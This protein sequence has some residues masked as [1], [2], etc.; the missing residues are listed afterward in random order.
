M[1]C[2]TCF[3]AFLHCALTSPRRL[4]VS[5]STRCTIGTRDPV[6]GQTSTYRCGL[7]SLNDW[8][9]WNVQPISLLRFFPLVCQEYIL[10]Y[11][12]TIISGNL[13]WNWPNFLS[14]ESL[15]Q[16]I[17]RWRTTYLKKVLLCF[18]GISFPLVSCRK[19]ISSSSL[20]FVSSWFSIHENKNLHLHCKLRQPIKQ[21]QLTLGD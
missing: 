14:H 10:F 21:R 15:R 4:R 6:N 5:D 2:D 20:G 18:I 16:K 7:A 17:T 8:R 19:L 11:I 9:L 12:C 1:E 3:N 13:H